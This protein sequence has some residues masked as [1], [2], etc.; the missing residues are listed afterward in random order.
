MYSIYKNKTFIGNIKNLN[1]LYRVVMSSIEDVDTVDMFSYKNEEEYRNFD[2]ELDIEDT[3]S[4]AIT[5]HKCGFD[6]SKNYP[7][8][9]EHYEYDIDFW[10][11]DDY[12]D[13]ATDDC[14]CE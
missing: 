9:R 11:D 2:F 12:S 5:D 10:D 3:I 13:N 1:E 6:C 14:Y 7:D 8:F 4:E